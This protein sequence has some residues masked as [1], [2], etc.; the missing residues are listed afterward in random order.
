[1]FEDCK[2]KKKKHFMIYSNNK[3][4]QPDD[5]RAEPAE[6]IGIPQETKT[7]QFQPPKIHLET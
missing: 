3:I 4:C 1:M 7:T 5:D 2:G 6:V